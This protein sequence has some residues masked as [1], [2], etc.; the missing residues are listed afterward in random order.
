MCIYI[1]CENDGIEEHSV[2]E[3][4]YSSDDDDLE[5]SF[6]FFENI[7]RFF[8]TLFYVY[9]FILYSFSH[10]GSFTS[11]RLVH[12]DFKLVWFIATLKSY[13][14]PDTISATI[15]VNRKYH[16]L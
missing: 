11:L 12:L 4:E 3:L 5:K 14:R 16:E 15:D 6:F 10:I 13:N 9:S 2:E 8:Y 7:K 1:V